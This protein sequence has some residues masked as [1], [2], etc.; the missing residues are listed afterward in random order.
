MTDHIIKAAQQAGF[1][2]DCCSL[3]WHER[4]ERF[5]AIAYRQGLED[6][7]NLV[8]LNAK[9]CSTG[10]AFHACWVNNAAAIRA[11]AQNL[12]MT[13]ASVKENGKTFT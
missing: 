5:Y 4:I 9:D 3:Q 1:E 2:L 13:A 8:Q 10:S 6:A 11:H 7:A 12:Y